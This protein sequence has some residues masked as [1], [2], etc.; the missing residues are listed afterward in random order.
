[1]A[2]KKNITIQ[3]QVSIN[4]NGWDFI[5]GNE[6]IDLGDCYIKVETV[7][8]NKENVS[9]TVSIK[10]NNNAVKKESYHFTPNMNSDNF[11]KQ[12]YLHLKTLPEFTNAVDC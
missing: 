12:A 6:T 1:M 5:K 8:G 9:Y 11:I 3:S 10:S 2:L 4:T 7:S